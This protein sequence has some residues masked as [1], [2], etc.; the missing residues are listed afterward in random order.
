MTAFVAFVRTY[1]IWLY[2]FC[3]IGILIAIKILADA[4]R[5]ARTTLFSLEQER[6]GEQ[7]YRA[8]MLIIVLVLAMGAV[9][10]VNAFIAP[11]V[12]TQDAVIP[13]G[14]TP[15][16]AAIIFPTSTPVPSATPLPVRPTETPPLIATPIAPT[17]TRAPVKPTSAP[18]PPPQPSRPPLP[19][20]AYALPAPTL[21]SP[22]N[23][24]VFTGFG[25]ASGAITFKW[26][27]DCAQ[28]ILGPN[29]RFVLVISYTDR[30]S[31]SVKSFGAGLRE[32]SLTMGNILKGTSFDVWHQAKDDA[33][34]W[35]VQVRRGD[36]PVTAPSETFSFIWH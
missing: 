36:Q 20:S 23:G 6:A 3:T 27:W 31:G 29:D 14:A 1:A 34:Q 7:T 8:L 13:R 33:Y 12:P 22:A 32:T 10:T 24:N 9:T 2:I 25:Q 17:A 16:L 26:T 30:S 15:T 35:Y 18:P 4:R 21:N 5:L 19:T 11:A 28:C